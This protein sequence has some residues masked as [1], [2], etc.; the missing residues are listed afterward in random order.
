MTLLGRHRLLSLFLL[1]Y[2]LTWW[3]VPLGSND[4]PVFPY[5]PF[6][7]LLLLVGLTSGRDGI[8]RVFAS[9]LNWRARPTWYAF[10]LLVPVAIAWSAM[11]LAR[12]LGAPASAMPGPSSTLEFVVVLPIMIIVGGPLGE[13][14]AWR[15]YALPV[16]QQR[17]R[18]LMAV[19]LL[20]A[21]HAIWHLPL[22]FTNDPP[23]PG[24][25]LLGLLSGG[26][27]LAWLWNSTG[28]IVIPILLHGANNMAEQAFENGFTHADAVHLQ[29][30]TAAG[31]AVVALTVIW[32]THGTLA[33]AGARPVTVPIDEQPQPAPTDLTPATTS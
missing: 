24:P 7:A 26:V 21:A 8:G 2:L 23:A 5:G 27:V 18:P 25:F 20:G 15:G 31:W 16:L 10:A 6:L 33:P 14:L 1:A 32:R 28:S 17:H 29:W 9:L 3:I 11:C 19:V 22:F 4:F 12:L 13:E 30:L